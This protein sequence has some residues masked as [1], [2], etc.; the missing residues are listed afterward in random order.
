MISAGAKRALVV[1]G[2]WEGHAPVAA[3]DRFATALKEDGYEVTV[4]D[5]LDSYLDASLLAATDL[6]VQC[7][8]MG[9]I[10]APQLEGLSQA[11]RAGTGLAGWHGGIVDA[12]RT[13][14]R[15]HLM[16][17]GQFVHHAREFSTFEVTP[18]PGKEDHPAVAGINAFTVTTEQYYVHVDPAIE[19]L[20]TSPYAADPD[21]P[22]LLGTVVPV[23]WTRNWGAGRVFVTTLGHGVA[24]LD[25][26]ETHAMIRK[27]M[28]WAT[29]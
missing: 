27:G 23:T 17:G 29:R 4:S 21:H 18:V 2:G 1:R 22:E 9:D 20:A 19:V 16:T 10:T 6:V 5:T 26:P 12:F 14:T 28:T 8:T 3:T 11:V 24:D 25:V 13:E 7:W 15:Y